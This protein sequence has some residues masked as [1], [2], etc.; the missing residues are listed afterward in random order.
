[1]NGFRCQSNVLC[2]S[3]TLG[4]L[5]IY[6]ICLTF[7]EIYDILVSI[8]LQIHIR[9]KETKNMQDFKMPY[10]E[11]TA[12]IGISFDVPNKKETIIIGSPEDV[13]RYYT[14]GILFENADLR[15]RKFKNGHQC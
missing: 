9:Q 13:K 12:S 5:R 8:K 7:V 6:G 2:Q 11:K 1:M 4:I 10:S 14:K 3:F 15:T